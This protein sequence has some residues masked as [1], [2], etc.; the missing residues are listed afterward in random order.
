[1]RCS[2]SE[3][4]SF[5]MAHDKSAVERVS[6]NKFLAKSLGVEASHII[7]KRV[8]YPKSDGG[9]FYAMN[10]EFRSSTLTEEVTQSDIGMTA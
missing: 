1:M 10:P 6:W 9:D 7:T 4:H 2:Y 8:A 5:G 3:Q